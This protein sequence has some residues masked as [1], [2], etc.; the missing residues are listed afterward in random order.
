MITLTQ[1][2]MYKKTSKPDMGHT[3][4]AETFTLFG[5]FLKRLIQQKANS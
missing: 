2:R 4:R 1:Y 3:L 5:R